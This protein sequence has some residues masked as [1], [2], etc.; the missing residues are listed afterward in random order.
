MRADEARWQAE[1]LDDFV[2][3][4]GDPETWFDSKGFRGRARTQI[5]EARAALIRERC[6]P[7]LG[8]A[9]ASRTA[10]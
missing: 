5:L 10:G 7:R 1:A 8:P 2:R 9:A 4:S 6:S 3:R